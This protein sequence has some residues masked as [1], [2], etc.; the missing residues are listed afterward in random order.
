MEGELEVGGS[1]MGHR[2]RGYNIHVAYANFY[3]EFGSFTFV[4]IRCFHE[5]KPNIQSATNGN[6]Y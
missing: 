6:R 2:R 1:R 3:Q 5:F 4:I